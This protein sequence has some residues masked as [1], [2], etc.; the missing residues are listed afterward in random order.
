MEI[1]D[2]T[3]ITGKGGYKMLGGG[4]VKFDP[5]KRKKRGGGGDHVKGGAQQVLG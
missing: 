1:K 4:H 5:Y 2:R 3:L